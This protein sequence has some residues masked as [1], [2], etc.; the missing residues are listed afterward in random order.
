MLA[1][2][3]VSMLWMEET[4]VERITRKEER[5]RKGEKKGRILEGSNPQAAFRGLD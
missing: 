1:E 3:E 4:E 5:G 2:R